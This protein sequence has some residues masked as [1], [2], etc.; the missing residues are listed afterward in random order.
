MWRARTRPTASRHADGEQVRKHQVGEQSHGDG[1]QSR[2][3]EQVCEHSRGQHAHDD[4]EQVGAGGAR[5]RRCNQGSNF[6]VGVQQ[7]KNVMI[8]SIWAGGHVSVCGP[9]PHCSPAAN[10]V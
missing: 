3:E 7:K 8:L 4:G 10:N 1:E 5:G 6:A 9:S 2:S